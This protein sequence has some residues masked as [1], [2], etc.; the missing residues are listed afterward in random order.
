MPPALS[1]TGPYASVAS[2]MPSVERRPTAEMATPYWPERALHARIVMAI[3]M[4]GMETE[5]MPTPS[6][7]MSTGAGPYSEAAE[8]S[9]VGAN[10]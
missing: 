2:V 3:E 6:P 7:L 8:M 10:S 9:R 4:V 5:N 1:A